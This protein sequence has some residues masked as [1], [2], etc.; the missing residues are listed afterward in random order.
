MRILI[1]EHKY[2]LELVR[3][4]LWEGISAEPD[5]T[6]TFKHVGYFYNEGRK[7]CVLLLPRVLLEDIAV[8]GEG[9]KSERVFVERGDPHDRAKVT[10]PGYA[11]EE[12]IDPDAKNASGEYLLKP[13]HRKFIREFAVWIYRAVELYWRVNQNDKIKSGV[14]HRKFIP[15][16]GR[17]P[18]KES[19]TLLD[20]ILALLE[21]Q[22]EHGD[23]ILTTLRNRQRGMS[24]VNWTRTVAK[25]AV[26]WAGKR[27]VY[28]APVNKKR[29]IDFEDELFRIY[30]SILDYVNGEFGFAVL[31]NPGFETMTDVEFRHCLAGAGRIRLRQIKGKYFSDLAVKLWELCFAFFDHQHEIRIRADKQEYLLAKNFQIVFEAII[32]ELIGDKDIPE[33]LKEQEDG[34]RV[35][36]MYR[37]RSLT[38]VDGENG[39][40]HE[41][42][43]TAFYIGDSKYYKRRTPI[44]DNSVYK[45]FT[46]AR[47]VIQWNLDLFLDD[48]NDPARQ[49]E[50]MR[51]RERFPMLRDDVTEGYAITPNFFISARI[52]DDLDYNHDEITDTL[53]DKKDFFSRQFENRLFDRDTLLV[54]HYDVNFLFVVSRYARNNAAQKREWREKVRGI[55]RDRVREMLMKRFEFYVMTP[56]ADTDAKEFFQEHFHD[57]V[58][59]IYNPYGKRGGFEYYSLALRKNDIAAKRDFSKENQ[60]IKDLVKKGFHLS[61]KPLEELGTPPEKVVAGEPRNSHLAMPSYMFEK[62]AQ[63]IGKDSYFINYAPGSIKLLKGTQA[64]PL[65]AGTGIKDHPENVRTIFLVESGASNKLKAVLQVDYLRE[66]SSFADLLAFRDGATDCSK[67]TGVQTGGKGRHWLWRVTDW[68]DV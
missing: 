45:Q 22:K 56:R 67:L 38:V 43:D 31:E 26:F 29:E 12:I 17:G 11:P 66:F 32:D 3:D 39:K 15:H 41:E 36:H 49:T 58:G 40:D 46:Y 33:G 25:S 23:F 7:D 6:V 48:D 10:F 53:K 20:V 18:L 51:E 2:P 54:A 28:I 4:D 27:P 50:R 35:D 61:E 5:G 37:F 47:N 13:E 42:S 60:K 64:F 8:T 34:K 63:A 52:D 1:E 65:L 9:E 44:P 62:A 55:F 24:K 19:H 16:M 30:H 21:F 14:I 57:L 59:R 68:V